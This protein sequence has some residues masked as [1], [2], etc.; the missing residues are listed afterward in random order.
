MSRILEI[1]MSTESHRS[2]LPA[3]AGGVLLAILADVEDLTISLGDTPIDAIILEISLPSDALPKV[4]SELRLGDPT[5]DLWS[6]CF[7]RKSS[8]VD[9]EL[10][11]E[12]RFSCPHKKSKYNCIECN[13]CP[14]HKVKYNCTEC[15]GCPHKKVK[16]NCKICDGC[17]HDMLKRSCVECSGCP[18]DKLR[19]KCIKCAP[20]PHKK[21]KN[22][23][24]KCSGCP[25][26][27][28]KRN[29]VECN[30]CPH[31]KLRYRCV[32]CRKR[33]VNKITY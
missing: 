21:V 33:K 6:E 15:N 10:R 22:N 27:R 30:R 9:S 24:V 23:C 12:E 4:D 5:S 1:D 14:H 18:H 19:Y 3:P 32:E 26:R 31:D 17:P 16:H 11:S 2:K 28:L 7:L 20:C 29:C 8:L 13:G 25:H